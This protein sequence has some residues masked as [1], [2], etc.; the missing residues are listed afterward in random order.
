MRLGLL[1][2]EIGSANGVDVTEQ[3]MN[4]LIM[5]AA[6][7]Y[8]GKD[9]ENFVRYI[10][11]EPMAAAQLRAPLYEDKVVDFLFAR[12][13][14]SDRKATRA[15]LEADLEAEEGHVHGPGCGHD[16]VE[17]QAE[18]EKSARKGQG[19]GSKASCQGREDKLVAEEPAKGPVEKASAKPKPAK[20][21]KDEPAKKARAAKA[22]AKSRGQE[23]A[24]QEAGQE[25]LSER[26]IGCEDLTSRST[27]CSARA[28]GSTSSILRT[29]RSRRS[30]PRRRESLRLVA[31]G[32]AGASGRLPEFQP[33]FVLTR[34][35]AAAGAGPRR[36]CSTATSSRPAG[37]TLHRLA[38]HNPRRRPRRR[39]GSLSSHRASDDLVRSGWVRVVYEDEGEPF[40]MEAGD[41]VLQPP[42]IRHR[43]LE[44][45]PGLE[46]IEIS[47]P[48]LHETFADHELKPAQLKSA[49]PD[50]SVG[51]R[52]LRH[53]RRDAVDRF[54]TGR[55][56]AGNRMVTRNQRPC[57]SANASSS[58]SGSR[59]VRAAS[60]R[61]GL[62]LR[63]RRLRQARC[64]TK[65][66]SALR[67]RSS[68]RRARAGALARP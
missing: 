13:K 6:S 39:L 56:S 16:H 9:R 36:E 34:A 63:P 1:L 58:N 65:L 32:C 50:A 15:E 24:S 7:Q 59:F 41:L 37:R 5:Q 51:Q 26:E 44:S 28:F 55:R 17:R 25:G 19:E 61:A 12:A 46:V 22:E 67:M 29:I 3:E 14:I 57:R 52:F 31:A 62:R 33:E 66:R 11:Q 27:I 4:R 21:L 68:S 35:G 8:Q 38:H 40:V 53:V 47:A 2:S 54:S 49:G 64:A 30:E 20:P 23:G 45:S 48:A 43:V 10:Q 18:G 42:L 60:R